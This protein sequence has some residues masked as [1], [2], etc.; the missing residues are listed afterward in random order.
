MIRYVTHQV[1]MNTIS[2][3]Q[4]FSPIPFIEY[5]PDI[6]YAD[7]VAH[8]EV[9]VN[10]N[11]GKYDEQNYNNI[12]FY[13]KDYNAS[14]SRTHIFIINFQIRSM[15]KITHIFLSSFEI[16]DSNESLSGENFLHNWN[17]DDV[18]SLFNWLFQ[19][20]KQSKPTFR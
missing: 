13:I 12:A 4:I 14:T 2:R 7:E 1:R 3:Y 16:I 19:C 6:I 15:W 10:S 8:D 20:G 9:D 17:L 5:H 11:Y 18:I